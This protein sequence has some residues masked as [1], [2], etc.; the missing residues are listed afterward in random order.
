[1]LAHCWE[2]AETLLGEHQC[3][4]IHTEITLQVYC[5]VSGA[6][7][8][9]LECSWDSDHQC[10]GP[11][12]D[13]TGETLGHKEN[14]GSCWRHPGRLLGHFL[15]CHWEQKHTAGHSA[16][17]GCRGQNANWG[18]VGVLGASCGALM[19]STSCCTLGCSSLDEE[20]RWVRVQPA[21]GNRSRATLPWK[22]G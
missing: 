21:W 17:K 15:R 19:R 18:L 5:G 2:Q 16:P 20:H 8:A 13:S 6:T 11:Y 4:W 9:L 22:R 12:R 1:M 7:R 10:W 3:S 14:D